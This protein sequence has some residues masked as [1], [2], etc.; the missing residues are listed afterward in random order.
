MMK[1]IS[2]SQFLFLNE[3]QMKNFETNEHKL[4]E[5]S[6]QI[7]TKSFWNNINNKDLEKYDVKLIET[8]DYYNFSKSHSVGIGS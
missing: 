7:F 4:A 3:S 1:L 8:I 5:L 2:R 6:N